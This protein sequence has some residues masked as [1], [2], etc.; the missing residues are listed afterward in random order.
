MAT[1]KDE[2]GTGW[3]RNPHPLRNPEPDDEPP[4]RD[5]PWFCPQCSMPLH[6]CECAD[7]K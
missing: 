6:R 1:L 3:V 5:A 7:G 4:E 2:L